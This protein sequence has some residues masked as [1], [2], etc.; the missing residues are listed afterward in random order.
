MPTI[1]DCLMDL[2][3]DHLIDGACRLLV[4]PEGDFDPDPACYVELIEQ[5]V[6]SNG[7]AIRR[8]LGL[9]GMDKLRTLLKSRGAGGL[10]TDVAPSELASGGL[11]LAAPLGVLAV[12]GLA[13]ED[14]DGWHLQPEVRRL[15]HIPEEELPRL[16]REEDIC[17]L[18]QGWLL[19]LGMV[20]FGQMR[21]L[22]EKELGVMDERAMTDV[23][24]ARM[25]IAATWNAPNGSLW[26]CSQFLQD[27]EALYN[28]LH[29]GDLPRLEYAAFPR[30]DVM[31]AAIM[32][33]PGSIE[34]YNSLSSYILRRCNVE[35]ELTA[36]GGAMFTAQ[37]DTDEAALAVLEDA[38][39]EELDEEGRAVF[40]A[41]M[42]NMPRWRTKGWNRRQAEKRLAELPRLIAT[43]KPRSLEQIKAMAT[44]GR[45]APCPCG[46]GMKFKN[47]C[48]RKLS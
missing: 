6:P 22:L 21:S 42:D 45:N 18:A 28:A 1:H 11:A 29:R 48:G 14:N 4:L 16:R 24:E 31:T 7:T 15:L 30:H 20:G 10:Q 44:C 38:L 27:A 46:S 33:L 3:Y 34:V 5:E 37:E 19:M 32:M 8:A 39:S 41:V 2:P 25:G 17:D 13:W 9:R 40:M 36:I 23:I 35:D 47:C 12:L 26:Y 43:A